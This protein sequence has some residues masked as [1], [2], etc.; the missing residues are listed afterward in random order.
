LDSDT[1]SESLRE[2]GDRVLQWVS[3]PASLAEAHTHSF[4]HRYWNI[5]HWSRSSEPTPS[6]NPISNLH[7]INK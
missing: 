6:F 5:D 2:E 7:F 3:C 4:S 1:D